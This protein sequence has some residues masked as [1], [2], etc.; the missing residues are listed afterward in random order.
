MIRYQD[1]RSSPVEQVQTV[2][3]EMGGRSN[4]GLALTAWQMAALKPEEW[5]P[6]AG[7][8]VVTA[9]DFLNYARLLNTGQAAALAQLPGAVSRSLMAGGAAGV[10]M[11][12][13]L[14]R[15]ARMNFWAIAQT[16]LNYD[17]SLLPSQYEGPVL[18]H[19]HLAD[20][21]FAF[22]Q[23]T[24]VRGFIKKTGTRGG[25]H[26]QQL[27]AALSCLARWDVK[28]SLLGFLCA[29]G[30]EDGYIALD[31]AL[32]YG[33]LSREALLAEIDSWPEDW[34]DGSRVR[35]VCGYDPKAVLCRKP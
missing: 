29:S 1:V 19:G 21:A 5:Q 11:L 24:F 4:S 3:A 34:Q 7:R 22:E 30:D 26:T 16:L 14:P 13:A 20:F 15:L 23:E 32:R 8:L 10:R 6:L 18:L 31:A 25:I 9:P 12:P 33:R 28:P 2:L 35:S 17:L 27:P